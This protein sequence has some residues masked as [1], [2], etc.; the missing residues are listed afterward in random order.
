MGPFIV[1]AAFVSDPMRLQ[2]T[3]KLNGDVMQDESTADMIFDIARQVEYLSSRMQLWPGDVVCTGSPAGNGAHY[4]R[5]LRDGDVMEGTI[6]E[7]GTIR[8][9]CV[10]APRV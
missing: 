4:G 7:I 8:N 1:P 2:I 6:A 3:L 9:P 10:A 5:Y